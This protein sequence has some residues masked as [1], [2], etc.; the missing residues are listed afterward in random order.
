MSDTEAKKLRAENE[1]LKSTLALVIQDPRVGEMLSL[2]FR[3]DR[4]RQDCILALMRQL[5]RSHEPNESVK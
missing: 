3:M 4:P 1:W 2:W 5:S